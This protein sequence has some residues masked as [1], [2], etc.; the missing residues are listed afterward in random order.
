MFTL[1]G[2]D[3]VD[4]YGSARRPGCLERRFGPQ[5]RD[6]DGGCERRLAG[7]GAGARGRRSWRRRR[8]ARRQRWRLSLGVAGGGVSCGGYA[9][10]G[11]W[12]R[13]PGGSVNRENFNSANINRGNSTVLISTATSMSTATLTSGRLLLRAR[14]GGR[15][16]R[17]RS[18]C[19]GRRRRHRCRHAVLLSDGP[20]ISVLPVPKLSELLLPTPGLPELRALIGPARRRELAQAYRRLARRCRAAEA[21][22]PPGASLAAVQRSLPLPS[23]GTGVLSRLGDRLRS[24]SRTTRARHPADRGPSSLRT[25]ARRNTDLSLDMARV[26]VT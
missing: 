23:N 7:A 24:P 3:R 17:C 21:R 13:V 15:C 6:R 18:G 2:A 14:L 22:Q 5:Y 8:L 16:R 9:G 12:A 20:G 11:S 10:R 25:A 19:R 26:T 4:G 1:H